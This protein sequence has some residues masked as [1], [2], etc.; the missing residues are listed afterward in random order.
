[1]SRSRADLGAVGA[2]DAMV[3]PEDLRTVMQFDRLEGLLAGMARGEGGMALR[4]PVLRQNDM[5]EGLG[6]PVDRR[7]HR[8]AVGHG[9]RAAGQ[10]IV[11]NVDDDED[12]L[13]RP[14]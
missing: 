13:L 2:L 3:G 1:M 10:E 4:M 14:A 6:E 11:L 5:A 8:I 9:E 7:D 12:V